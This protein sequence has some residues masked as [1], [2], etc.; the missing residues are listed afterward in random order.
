[1]KVTSFYSSDP[2]NESLTL[3]D[4]NFSNQRVEFE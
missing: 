2:F 4:S 3:V 1:M